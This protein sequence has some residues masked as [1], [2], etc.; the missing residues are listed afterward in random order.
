M[1]MGEITNTIVHR[2][3]NGFVEGLIT[4]SKY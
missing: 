2:H 4:D 1:L 3:S